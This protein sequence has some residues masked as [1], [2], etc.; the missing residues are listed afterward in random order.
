MKYSKSQS[1]NGFT[2]IE[3]LLYISIASS[4]LFVISLF[5][6]T[7]LEARTKNTAINEVDSTGAYIVSVLNQSLHNAASINSPSPGNNGVSLSINTLD[8]SL[9]PTVFDV[10]SGVF[11]IKE[12]TN[13]EVALSNSNVSISSLD[14]KNLTV[15]GAPGSI[16]Y[17]FTVSA[18]SASGRQEYNYSQT[19][20]GGASLRK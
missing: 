8:A 10:S 18:S 7:I 6:N 20:Y 15:S 19:F 16:S 1:N 14:F 17:S 11:R 13:S 2:M 12:G 4:L 5:T 3:M 9:N